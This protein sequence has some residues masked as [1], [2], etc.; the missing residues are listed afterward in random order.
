MYQTCQLLLSL[1]SGRTALIPCKFVPSKLT[2]NLGENNV[3]GRAGDSDATR[4]IPYEAVTPDQA[5]AYTL[6][7]E[8]E[9]KDGGTDHLFQS[10]ATEIVVDRDTKTVAGEQATQCR[11]AQISNLSTLPGITCS[12]TLAG[13]KAGST[14]FGIC[15]E[16]CF[17]PIPENPVTISPTEIASFHPTQPA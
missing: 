6:K 9:F 17:A 11:P 1:L 16:I 15:L 3:S 8:V 14:V 5:G 10:V 12:S 7:T 13:G 4:T 2:L